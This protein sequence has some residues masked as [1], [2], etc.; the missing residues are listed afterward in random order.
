M[1]LIKLT[2]FAKQ[3]GGDHAYGLEGDSHKFG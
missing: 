1:E 2:V 3:E